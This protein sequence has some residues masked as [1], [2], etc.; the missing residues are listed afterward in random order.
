MGPE[1]LVPSR[2]R[3]CT[4][5]RNKR[6]Q[7]MVQKERRRLLREEHRRG[8]PL[9]IVFRKREEEAK[10]TQTRAEVKEKSLQKQ[11]FYKR[12]GRRGCETYIVSDNNDKNQKVGYKTTRSGE[13]RLFLRAR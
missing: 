2:N 4:T 10:Q 1:P 12:R 8:T 5:I 7:K 9:I 11:L 6:K 13:A 3:G